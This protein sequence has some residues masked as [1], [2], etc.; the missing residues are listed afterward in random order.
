MMSGPDV[1][2]LA[3]ARTTTVSAGL[4]AGPPRGAGNI[5]FVLF[6]VPV[7]SFLTL[8]LLHDVCAFL[9]KVLFL[10]YYWEVTMS[11]KLCYY[12]NW[13]NFIRALVTKSEGR[14]M[15][16]PALFPTCLAGFAVCSRNVNSFQIQ[17]CGVL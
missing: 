10:T 6:Y 13:V 2:F 15:L 12:F 8:L 7:T 9:N 3:L 16:C 4:A 14:S 17:S 1:L 11:F 5:S